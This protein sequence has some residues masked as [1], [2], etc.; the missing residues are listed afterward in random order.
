MHPQ[1]KCNLEAKTSWVPCPPDRVLF[2]VL[3]N[4]LIKVKKLYEAGD[5]GTDRGDLLENICSW[6]N[7]FV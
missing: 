6:Y 2:D 1:I 4:I 7:R 3:V 5:Y